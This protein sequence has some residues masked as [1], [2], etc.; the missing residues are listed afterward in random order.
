MHTV[1]DEKSLDQL[2]EEKELASKITPVQEAEAV[3]Q[4]ERERG[5]GVLTSYVESGRLLSVI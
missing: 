5:C 2:D 4:K 1:H 3:D